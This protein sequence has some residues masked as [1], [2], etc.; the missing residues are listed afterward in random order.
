VQVA[1]LEQPGEANMNTREALNY[2]IFAINTL[3]APDASDPAD[4][5]ALLDQAEEIIEV[6]DGLRRSLHDG[7]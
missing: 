5:D 2:A 3:V 7:H 1:R 4:W 6:L